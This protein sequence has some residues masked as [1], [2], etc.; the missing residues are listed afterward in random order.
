[1]IPPTDALPLHVRQATPDDLDVV[2]ELLHNAYDWLIAQGIIDQ[3]PG[4]FPPQAIQ[5]LIRRRE[6]HIASSGNGVIA[7][8]TLSYRPD[9]ELWDDPPDNAGYIRRLVVAREHA[10]L[11]IGGQ[12]LDHAS[13]LIAATGRPWLRLDCA[14][15]NTRLHDYYRAHGFT[16]LRTIDLP[17]RQSG[18][19]FQ[20]PARL[21][22]G[23]GLWFD[24]SDEASRSAA[25][26]SQLP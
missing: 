15:H 3:W 7:T 8:F 23:G 14:K 9:P 25:S 26:L 13:K 2:V 1:M 6:V 12:L 20:R 18:A 4:P 17:H 11:E 19:L 24:S 5:E 21:A 10:G 16:H 22:M